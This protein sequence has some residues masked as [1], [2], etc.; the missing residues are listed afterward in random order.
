MANSSHIVRDRALMIYAL[1]IPLAICGGAPTR[2][3]REPVMMG[4]SLDAPQIL[5]VVSVLP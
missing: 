5:L 4:D 3:G 1:C 2:K